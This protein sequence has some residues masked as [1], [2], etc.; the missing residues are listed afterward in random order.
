MGQK[1]LAPVEIAPCWTSV[2]GA[3]AGVLRALGEAQETAALMGVTGNAFRLA[4]TE[5]EGVLAAA[6]TATA[7]DFERALPLFANAG[8]KLTLLTTTTVER[9][10]VK[11]RAE[12]LKRARKSIDRGRPVIT[13]EIHLPEFGVI[14][15]Y[16]ERAQT[17][18]VGSMMSGQ[19][20]ARLGEARWPAPERP[21]RLVMLIPSDRVRTEARRALGDALRFAV[22]YAEHGDPGD[23]SGATHGLA[24]YARWRLAF[25]HGQPVDPSGQAHLIQTVQTARRD[26]ARFLR[27]SS[28]AL[29]SPTA[30]PLAEAGAAYDRVALAFSRMASFFPF[31][32]GGDVTGQGA[33]VVALGALREAE[34]HERSA[35]AAL[36]AAL[37]VL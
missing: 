36:A 8:R 1:Q 9:D 15:G 26:A 34:A 10:Y 14:Y 16:D 6:P 18:T 25:E 12:M 20:G 23:P 27:E 21:A 13:N 7:V 17:L 29:P 30:G 28:A 19:Y 2:V 22:S 3:L 33:R 37:R 11:R 32:S 5:A 4:L 24:A 35:L 31:P